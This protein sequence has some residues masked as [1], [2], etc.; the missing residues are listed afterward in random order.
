MKSKSVVLIFV[1]ISILLAAGFFASRKFSRKNEGVSSRA[2]IVT[3]KGAAD[4]TE[5]TDSEH[6][7]SGFNSENFDTFIRLLPSE[8]LINTITID[9]NN[10][11]YDDEVITVRKTGSQ[12][13]T[14]IPGLFNPD[15][16]DY[17]RLKSI[18]TSIS[19]IRTF[20]LSGMDLTGDHRNALVY[21]GVADDENYVMEVFLWEEK[22]GEGELV[23]IGDFVS[24][25]TI[26]IQQTERSDS[27]QLSLSKGESFS[28]WVYE[29]EKVIDEE[30][31]ISAGPNQIQKEYKWNASVGKYELS[32]TIKV[33]AGRL[34]ANELSRIQDGTVETFAAFLNG[35]W[36]KTS[37]EDNTLRYIH[38]DYDKKEIILLKSDS[39]E[40]YE[41]DDSKLRHNGIY[42]YTV[43]SDITNL[44]RRF[45][46]LLT[47]TEEIKITLYDSI[48]LII[49]E[50]SAWDGQYKKLGLQSSIDENDEE[51]KNRFTTELESAAAWATEDGMNTFSLKDFRYTFKYD[52]MQEEGIFSMMKIGSYNVLELR[53]TSFDSILNQTYALEFGTKV[54]TETVK[55]KT[56]EKVVTDYDTIIFTPVKITPTD[57]FST[58]GKS[59]T[60]VKVKEE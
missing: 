25:G 5:D 8:T 29:S 31:N 15:S 4:S 52:N 45:D 6:Q 38:F 28:V 36:Y 42:L 55:R 53:A 33:T 14:I 44:Q 49:K 19:R 54:I 40:I 57:C 20:S 37:N 9:F 50:S 18:P 43:N 60:F 58:D 2:K 26:F 32:N 16:A 10:D 23:N 27:Y 30:G 46:V 3:P 17:D 12:A 1:I 59:Y 7:S 48:G 39:Q 21:Q 11:G 35:L 24:D 41:W 51:E 22:G 56:V 13:F 34:A 47:S